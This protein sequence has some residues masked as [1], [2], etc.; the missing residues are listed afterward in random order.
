MR[1]VKAQAF[2][3]RPLEWLWKGRIPFKAVYML[4]GDGGVSKS[5]LTCTMAAHISKG[6]NWPDGA[7]C[8]AG[9]TILCNNEDLPEEI[10]VPRLIAAGA[11]RERVHIMLP[12]SD[13]DSF[14]IPE[15]IE[16]LER[17]IAGQD[18]RL[19]VF[20]PMLDYLST[21]TSNISEQQVRRAISYLT[22]FAQRANLAI[23]LIRHLNK[24][25]KQNTKYRGSG[26][27]AF[28]ALARAGL[29]VVQDPSE[30]S[31]CLMLPNKA[32]WSALQSGLAYRVESWEFEAEGAAIETSRI[33]W[34]GECAATT[35]DIHAL[36]MTEMPERDVAE[37]CQ[38][39]RTVLAEG[40]RTT[41]QLF[42]MAGREGLSKGAVFR[43]RT[44]LDLDKY[45][46]EGEWRWSLKK[47]G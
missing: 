12:G 23:I 35:D 11:D 4:D 38:F 25:A 16:P 9:R 20:D 19:I 26:S 30:R 36:E 13:G 5:T 27:V 46:Q 14:S 41:E 2:E 42:N 45:Y 40:P 31:R 18:V 7:A 24:D 10:I 6:E 17:E 15:K 21:K 22:A 28:Y 37:A 44:L 39:L 32:N 34:D 3:P 1:L 47:D 8:P 33:V 43:A 29:M